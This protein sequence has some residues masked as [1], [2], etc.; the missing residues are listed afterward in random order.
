[1]MREISMNFIP[2]ETDI[3]IFSEVSIRFHPGPPG[4]HL[5]TKNHQY[6]LVC[7]PRQE[8]DSEPNPNKRL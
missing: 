4:Y 3:E 7:G 1:M 5:S 8:N 2:K 6:I